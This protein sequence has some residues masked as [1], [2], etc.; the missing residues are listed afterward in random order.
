MNDLPDTNDQL[1]RRMDALEGRVEELER[2]IS[3]RRPRA[4]I[5][6]GTPPGTLEA[7]LLE[8][9][10]LAQ[11]GSIFS[12]LGKAMLGIAGA[13]L[14]RA[15]AEASIAP[16]PL[17]AILGIVYATLWL[18]VAARARAES[19]VARLVYSATSAV[20]LA[21]ML[22][23][24]AIRF[25]VLP[26]SAIAAALA[27]YELAAFFLAS[28]SHRAVVLQI[29]NTVVAVLGLAL[30][31]AMHETVPFIAVLIL[32][33]ALCEYRSARGTER[34]ARM[35]VALAADTAV[36]LLIY[37]YSIPQNTRGDYPALGSAALLAPGAL[38]FLLY[39]SSA[40]F[41]VFFKSQT[42]TAFEIAQAT[43]TFLLASMALIEFG[44][45][46]NKVIL[47]GICIALAAACY[48]GSLVLLGQNASWRNTA[49]FSTWSGVLLLAGSFLSL[50]APWTAAW[51]CV[52]ALIAVVAGTRLSRVIL[53][54]H[55]AAF[56]VAAAVPSGLV[57]YLGQSLMGTPM[58][59][60]E[61]TIFLA[62][63]SAAL[64]YSAAGQDRSDGWERQTLN[65]LL[66]AIAAAALTAMLLQGLTAMVGLGMAPATDHLAFLRTLTLC[67]VS[68]ALVFGGARLC[69]PEL[70]RLGYAVIALVAVKLIIEDLRHGHLE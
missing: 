48:A 15:G 59:V 45:A 56:L 35:I 12:V 58:G 55:G 23:E 29:G 62:M 67:S 4:A 32:A 52:A 19:R 53:E 13:Y 49:V 37:I 31:I 22:W 65:L 30:A 11:S 16:R 60:P 7:V 70:S 63:A 24:L 36:W 42:I 40:T 66:A 17:V 27:A 10:A 33:A 2:S 38:L 14:L 64:C 50:R 28:Q 3:L 43:I 21:P 9:N 18:L 47:G 6:A 54:F 41:K 69:R 39:S 20:I 26:A 61:T 46:S 57:D 8:N 68:L 51:L 25:K 5:V 44:P 34:S 1:V